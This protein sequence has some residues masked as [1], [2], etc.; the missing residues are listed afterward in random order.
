MTKTLR[1]GPLGRIGRTLILGGTLLAAAQPAHAWRAITKADLPYLPEYCADHPGLNNLGLRPSGKDWS[2]IFGASNWVHMS[3]YCF[4]VNNLNHALRNSRN[5]RESTYLAGVAINEFGYV[6]SHGDPA[7]W[8]LAAEAYTHIA[9]AQVIQGRPAQAGGS[10]EKA[11]QANPK[12]VPAYVAL[13][14]MYMMSK[15]NKAALEVVEKGLANVPDSRHL[16]SRFQTLTGK[17][18]VPPPEAEK[19]AAP[20]NESAA[21][22]T[23]ATQAPATPT[24]PAGAVSA[25]AGAAP[26]ANPGGNLGTGGL[27]GN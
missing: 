14:E 27:I 1:C 3:H 13:A 5:K 23:P 8:P 4:G 21:T 9:R 24:P 2:S 18:F 25:S 7:N 26:A 22:A 11:I 10:L 15:N 19:P 16:A 12:F 6:F 20:A 17:A